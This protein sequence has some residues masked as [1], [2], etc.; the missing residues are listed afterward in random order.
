MEYVLTLFSGLIIGYLASAWS[1][2]HQAILEFQ[3]IYWSRNAKSLLD[4]SDKVSKLSVVIPL[5]LEKIG[6]GDFLKSDDLGVLGL[7]SNYLK[8]ERLSSSLK[9]FEDHLANVYILGG[10]EDPD[11]NEIIQNA[12]TEMPS[13]NKEIQKEIDEILFSTMNKRISVTQKIKKFFKNKAAK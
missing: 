5:E 12:K 1:I 7:H 4:L 8:Y 3:K 13:L 2:K 6:A 10:S 11:D 9:Q